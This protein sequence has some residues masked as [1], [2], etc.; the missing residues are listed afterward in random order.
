MARRMRLLLLRM[1]K[2]SKIKFE[3]EEERIKVGGKGFR[4]TIGE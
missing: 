1:V 3:N 2:D 4:V